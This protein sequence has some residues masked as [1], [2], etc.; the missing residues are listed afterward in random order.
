MVGPLFIGET[1]ILRVLYVL[2]WNLLG[3][4]S[5]SQWNIALHWG[6]GKFVISHRYMQLLEY[7]SDFPFIS[8]VLKETFR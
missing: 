5:H 4:V 1:R 7:P 3:N 2:L 6:G 8:A